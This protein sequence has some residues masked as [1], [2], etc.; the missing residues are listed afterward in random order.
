MPYELEFQTERV[1][2]FREKNCRLG[3]HFLDKEKYKDHSETLAIDWAILEEGIEV[4]VGKSGDKASG[5]WGSTMGK[6][7]YVFETIKGK[8]YTILASVIEPDPALAVT[9]PVLKVVIDRVEHKNAVVYPGLL[10]LTSYL[11]IVIAAAICFTGF[12]FKRLT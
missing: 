9:D 8:N 2:D 3:I 10:N 1:L 11:L 6:T 12:I 4:A 7:L 5:F